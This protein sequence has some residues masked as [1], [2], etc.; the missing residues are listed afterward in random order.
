[1]KIGLIEIQL[2]SDGFFKLDGGAMFGIVPKALWEKRIPAD[3]INRIQLGLW[4]LLIQTNGKNILV[5]TG[6]GQNEKYTE[7]FRQ[8]YA[9]QHPPDLISSLGTF[10]LTPEDIDIVINTHLHFD[11]C[12]GNTI[13]EQ[14]ISAPSA[15]SVNFIPTFP[16]AKYVIQQAEWHK[17]LNPTELSRAS[18]RLENILPLKQHGLLKLIEGNQ[19]VT[20]GVRVLLTGGHTKGHQVVI[21][22]SEGKKGIYWSDLMPTTAHLDLPY[23]MAYDLYP[24]ET[25][26]IKKYL[27]ELAIKEK[28]LCFWEHDPKIN[29][30]YLERKDNKIIITPIV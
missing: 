9:I 20:P 27:I 22:E 1:M 13:P 19:E 2:I 28:W 7:R 12:G 29:C 16:Q 21:I 26:A 8:I 30:G 18:Y 15:S 23:I 3:E 6:I 17:A 4:C 11:H 25:L 14:L 5:N 10:N 24:E